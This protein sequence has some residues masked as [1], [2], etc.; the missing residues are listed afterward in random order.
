MIY[1]VL[2]KLDRSAKTFPS[3]LPRVIA[4]L[5]L[6]LL[7]P[8]GASNL[9]VYEP[10]GVSLPR[11]VSAQLPDCPDRRLWGHHEAPADITGHYA[12]PP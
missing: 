5:Q 6:S 8:R 3:P 9:S 11:P 2:D 10:I 12:E 4:A 7:L 1:S